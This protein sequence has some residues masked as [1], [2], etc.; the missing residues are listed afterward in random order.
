MHLIEVENV[1]YFRGEKDLPALWRDVLL[2]S[3]VPLNEAAA[4][5]VRAVEAV[6]TA[7]APLIQR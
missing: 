2:V 5:L 4:V 3:V 6:E 7:V 1:E